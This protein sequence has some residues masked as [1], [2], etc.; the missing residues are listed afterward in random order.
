M[1]F[2][3]YSRQWPGSTIKRYR[4]FIH[5]LF[6]ELKRFLTNKIYIAE[7]DL[8]DECNLRCTH[9]YHFRS[10]NIHNYT[11]LPIDKWESKF[12]LLYKK[13]IRRVL[14]IGGEPAVRM[15]VIECASRFFPYIDICSNGTI[16]VPDFYKQKI[17][18]SIDGDEKTHDSIRGDGV[19][20]KII[21]NYRGDKRVVISMT[22]TK[23]NYDKI[24]DVV[25]LAKENNMIGVSCDVYTPAPNNSKSDPMFITENI[26]QE[27]ILEMKRLKKMYPKHFLKSNKAI[28]WFQFPNHEK[29]KC[30]WRS[31]VI[32]FDTQLNEKPACDYYDCSNC[33][34]FAGAN[35]SPLNFLILEKKK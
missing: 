22:V 13:G 32:H 2:I 27:I 35:L 8:S 3:Y 9:C 14:L 33:G 4:R 25:K 7:F 30:Y 20:K 12:K 6:L 1:E 29:D 15:D 34:H 31:A 21:N 5:I 26:R 11:P 28:K 19:F 16:R 24:E 17:F 23:E 10:K 18:V